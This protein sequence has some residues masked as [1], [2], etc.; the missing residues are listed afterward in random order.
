M[1]LG[2]PKG[3]ARY[4]MCEKFFDLEDDEKMEEPHL[5]TWL[6]VLKIQRLKDRAEKRRTPCATSESV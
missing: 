5:S 4:E 6:Q 2:S 1:K 3:V